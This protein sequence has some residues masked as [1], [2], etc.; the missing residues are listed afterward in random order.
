MMTR[1][2]YFDLDEIT[3]IE[4]DGVDRTQHPEY[5]DAFICAALYYG[6]PMTEEE[7]EVLNEEYPDFVFSELENQLY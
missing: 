2:V 1:T 6:R 7:L 4:F 5:E 3:H